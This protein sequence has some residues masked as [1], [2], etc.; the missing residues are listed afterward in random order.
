V[1]PTGLGDPIVTTPPR[2][3]GSIRRTSHVD[4]L[5]T[6]DGGLVLRGSARDL[7]TMADREPV[8]TGSARVEATLDG[9]HRLVRLR[10]DLPAKATKPLLGLPV[11]RGFRGAVDAHLPDEQAAGTPLYLLLDEL[12]MAALIS[13]YARLYSGTIRPTK[14]TSAMVKADICSGWRSDGTMVVSLRTKGTMPVPLGPEVNDLVPADDVDAWHV[15]DPLPPGG[16]RRQRL[17]D[18]APGDP[19]P[20]YA[21]F[22]DSHAD[23]SGR[24]TI[25]HEYSLTAELDP[26]SFVLGRCAARPQVLPWPEC[27]AAADSARQLDGLG[28]RA[29]RDVVRERFRGTTTCTHLNDLL[30]S[31]GDLATLAVALP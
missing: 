19:M 25:L 18:L 21:M 4:M 3:P 17:L 2:A 20:V 12:P 13:G 23:A 1:E 30:R 7:A 14:E 24:T 26:K 9:E 29:V 27:P 10:S 11:R 28:V 6:D 22:R 16:M 8:L 5:P 15:V 31:L